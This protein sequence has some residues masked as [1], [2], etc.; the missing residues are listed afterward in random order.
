MRVKLPRGR[1]LDG[2]SLA[3]FEKDRSQLDAVLASAPASHI[4]QAR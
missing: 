3:N 4:A 2:D 1:V